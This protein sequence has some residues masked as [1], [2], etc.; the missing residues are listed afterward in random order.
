M[1][2]YRTVVVGV[3]GSIPAD[4]K[5]GFRNIFSHSKVRQKSPT[6][7][8]Y[9]SLHNISGEIRRNRLNISEKIQPVTG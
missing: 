9:S 1:V 8:V 6:I 2:G 7:S 4:S 3:S 5:F